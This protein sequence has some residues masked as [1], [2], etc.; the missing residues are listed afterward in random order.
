[1]K[2]SRYSDA[3]T[4]GHTNTD[5]SPD[6]DWHAR[7]RSGSDGLGSYRDDCH[8]PLGVDGKA[9]GDR[10]GDAGIHGG[11]LTPHRLT[12]EVNALRRFAHLG[13][14]HSHHHCC[15]PGKLSGRLSTVLPLRDRATGSARL[16]TVVGSQA[17][18]EPATCCLEGI[19]VNAN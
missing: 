15:R 18:F 8:V 5:A 14:Y 6:R 16:Y 11:R 1:M 10:V 13:E 3:H 17:G 9:S 19:S 12:V 4:D 2:N 7:S